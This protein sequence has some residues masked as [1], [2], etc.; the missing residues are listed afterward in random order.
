MPTLLDYIT[1]GGA[2]ASMNNQVALN[3]EY[4]AHQEEGNALLEPTGMTQ[5]VEELEQNYVA[6]VHGRPADLGGGLYELAVQVIASISIRDVVKLIGDGVAFDL[7]KIGAKSFVFRPMLD[8]FRKLKGRSQETVVDIHE[9][10]FVFKDAEIIISRIPGCSIYES[11]KD[12]FQV[13][14]ENY[15]RLQANGDEPPYEIHV[16]VFEDPSNEICRFRQLLDVDETIQ[17]ANQSSYLKLWGVRYDFDRT[18]RVFDIKQK[19][20]VDAPYLTVDEY[21][22]AWDENRRSKGAA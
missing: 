16:P 13:L 17:D 3:I 12:V 22:K 21:W 18:V 5:F 4:W 14:V 15:P 2:G 9:I 10:R 6:R 19:V 11:L 8:A 1:L 7:L 20:L